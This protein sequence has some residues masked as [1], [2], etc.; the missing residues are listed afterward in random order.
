ML[1]SRS[2]AALKPN[3]LS[4]VGGGLRGILRHYSVNDLS[5]G[6]NVDEFLRLVQAYQFSDKYG[7]V[8]PAKWRPGGK[9]LVPQPNSSKTEEYWQEELS[10]N[11]A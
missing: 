2:T 10:K 7:E 1:N 4:E 6:R 3:I 8:C 9:T 5:A 11:D